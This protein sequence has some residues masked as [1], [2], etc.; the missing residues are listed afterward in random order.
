MHPLHTSIHSCTPMHAHI[1]LMHAHMCRCAYLHTHQGKGRGCPGLPG[2]CLKL[3]NTMATI[4]LKVSTA[5]LY[6]RTDYSALL[7]AFLLLQTVSSTSFPHDVSLQNVHLAF[8]CHFGDVLCC[9]YA[10]SCK[11]KLETPAPAQRHVY[12]KHVA[13][14]HNSITLQ[15][16]H[17]TM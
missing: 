14:A 3:S 16:L 8:G 11:P 12:A 9:H 13:T 7:L 10:S 2:N 4:K 5:E 6:Q 17:Y 15:L 1:H